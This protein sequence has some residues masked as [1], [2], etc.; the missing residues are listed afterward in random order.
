MLR[1]AVSIEDSFSTKSWHWG[2]DI[3]KVHFVPTFIIQF[4]QQ[5]LR[6]LFIFQFLTE[7]SKSMVECWHETPN[8][9]LTTLNLMKKLNKLKDEFEAQKTLLKPSRGVYVSP[10][11][12]N[13]SS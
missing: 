1:E 11:V 2:I 8:K 3:C 7:L 6:K 5:E 4:L 13:H 12:I 10:P 9:R